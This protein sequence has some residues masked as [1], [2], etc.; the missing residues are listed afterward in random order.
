MMAKKI[1]QSIPTKKKYLDTHAGKAYF[2]G[3]D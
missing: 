2:W 1:I 3:V